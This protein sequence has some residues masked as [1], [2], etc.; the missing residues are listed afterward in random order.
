M[1]DGGN[2][3]YLFVVIL[4]YQATIINNN[5]KNLPLVIW[6]YF[7]I[8]IKN[9][10]FFKQINFSYNVFGNM[11]CNFDLIICLLA[12]Y[13]SSWTLNHFNIHNQIEGNG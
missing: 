10:T 11:S 4:N 3:F 9:N 13:I 12:V 2:D 8:T 7:Y 1:N 6:F 5:L